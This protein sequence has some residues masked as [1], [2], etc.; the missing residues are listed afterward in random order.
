M[1]KNRLDELIELRQKY[2][3]TDESFISDRM[4]EMIVHYDPLQEMI[5]HYDPLY[6]KL[7]AEIA[8]VASRRSTSRTVA[9]RR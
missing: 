4:Q 2:T 3:N 7:D 9:C 6:K 1:C 8:K 5:V